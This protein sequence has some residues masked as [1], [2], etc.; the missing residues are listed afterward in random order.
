M[1]YFV[2][3][4]NNLE[5]QGRVDTAMSISLTM[6]PDAMGKIEQPP[7][8]PADFFIGNSPG[9]A[10]WIM[11]LGNGEVIKYYVSLPTEFGEFKQV[12]HDLPESIPLELRQ[13]P[14]ETLCEMHLKKLTALMEEVRKE[15]LPR[16]RE[17]PQLRIVK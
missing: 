2:D 11:H 7:F 12:F 6:T 9:E 5:K 3:A 14:T 15:F 4:R 17:R 16:K 10:G 1:R 13:L 8:Q